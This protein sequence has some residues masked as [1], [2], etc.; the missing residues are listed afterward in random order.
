MP[1]L[2]ESRLQPAFILDLADRHARLLPQSRKR[3]CRLP[4]NLI[5][6]AQQDHLNLEARSGQNSRGNHP[7]AAVVSL[8]AERNHSPR[9]GILPPRKPRDRISSL[10]HQGTER[11]SELFDR[12]PIGLCHLRR[13][14]NSH[15]TLLPHRAFSSKKQEPCNVQ[16]SSRSGKGFVLTRFP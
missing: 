3:H 13:C 10:F 9:R 6:T 16:G 4:L 15:L 14:K 1:S 12:P 2:I 11:D 5:H 7:I 8:S